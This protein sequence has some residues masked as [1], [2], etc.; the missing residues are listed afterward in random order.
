MTI[1]QAIA[2]WRRLERGGDQMSLLESNEATERRKAAEAACTPVPAPVRRSYRRM[3]RAIEKKRIKAHLAERRRLE[4]I[5]YDPKATE[6]E[7]R[8]ARI[9][10]A[11]PAVEEPRG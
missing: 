2:M 9:E 8:L 6:E 10:L 5:L 4:A 1:R 11:T 7:K 3:E